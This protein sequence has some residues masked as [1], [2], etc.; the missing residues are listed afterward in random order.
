[1]GTAWTVRGTVA[2]ATAKARH[3]F[4]GGGPS[5]IVTTSFAAV[6]RDTRTSGQNRSERS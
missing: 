3:P 5:A 6:V 4:P 2:V 1:M